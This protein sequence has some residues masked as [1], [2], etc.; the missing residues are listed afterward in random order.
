MEEINVVDINYK[1][2]TYDTWEPVP[3]GLNSEVRLIRR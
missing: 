1:R 2:T 3:S